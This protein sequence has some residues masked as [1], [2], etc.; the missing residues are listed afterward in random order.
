[1][2]DLKNNTVDLDFFKRVLKEIKSNQ[3][4]SADILDSFSQTQFDS[5]IKLFEAM[6]SLDIPYKDCNVAIFGSWYGSIL[7]A[8]LA[9]KVKAITAIDLDNET[10][11]IAKN[12]FFPNSNNIDFITGDV[13][14][15]N[16]SRY[17][18][19]NLFI[20]TSCEHMPAV[21]EW[22]MWAGVKEGSWF[23][24]QSNNMEGITEHVNCVHSAKEFKK[25]LPPHFEVLIK[26]ENKD[27]RGTRFTLIG[28]I[29]KR[30]LKSDPE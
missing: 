15:T 2:I 5:K 13:A 28:K 23:A 19:C 26:K 22:S 6:D 7:I 9:N 20:N 3:E 12:K 10:V 17:Q 11:K 27:D 14:T 29:G 21:R 24:F 8:D 25:Q 30:K 4:R 1:M 18:D 16:L